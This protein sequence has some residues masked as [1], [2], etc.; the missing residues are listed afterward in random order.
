MIGPVDD[1]RALKTAARKRVVDKLNACPSVI[2][3]SRLCKGGWI[4]KPED[5]HALTVCGIDDQEWKDHKKSALKC[6]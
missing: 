6:V 4:A 2:L 1:R 5:F 3:S